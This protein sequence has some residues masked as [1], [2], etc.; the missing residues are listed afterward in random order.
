MLPPL[1]PSAAFWGKARPH[2]G[3]AMSFHPLTAHALDVAA[4]AL[5]LPRRTPILD[6]RM[7]GLL[8]ALHDL[9]K[10]SRPFQAQVPEHWPA[11]VLGPLDPGRMPPP[12]PRHDA[13]TLRLLDGMGD[14]LDPLLPPPQA[15]RSA[16]AGVAGAGRTSRSARA[17]ARRDSGGAV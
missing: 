14:L 16:A 15:G 13:M 8:V 1:E 17:Q 5:L 6:G 7:L 12:A 9:G 4:V 11:A 2:E 3:A 10:F